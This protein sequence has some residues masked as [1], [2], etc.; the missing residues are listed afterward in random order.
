VSERLYTHNRA[1]VFEDC[2]LKPRDKKTYNCHHIIHKRDAKKK[3]LTGFNVN[4]K[5]NL[6][7]LREDIHERLHQIIDGNKEWK[8]DMGLRVYFANMAFCG[9]LC[10]IPDRMF[11]T[12]PEIIEKK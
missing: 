6:I 3:E 1:E 5:S 4:Q 8:N 7:P 11:R 12:Y 2:G 10:D 9:D